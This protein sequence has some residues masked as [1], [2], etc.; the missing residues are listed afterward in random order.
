M[1]ITRML[2]VTATCGVLLLNSAAWSDQLEIQMDGAATVTAVEVETTNPVTGAT[3]ET[4][5]TVKDVPAEATAT[6]P[7]NPG[8][9]QVVDV[10]TPQ[11][12]C[13]VDLEVTSS[14]GKEIDIANVDI[15]GLDGLTVEAVVEVPKVVAST[16]QQEGITEPTPQ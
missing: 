1:M 8:D 10:V 13:V 2:V 15:C 9:A 5:L 16:T 11:K 4:D 3:A 12:Q 6:T 14:Q 7:T